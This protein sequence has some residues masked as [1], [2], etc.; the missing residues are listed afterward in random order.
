L[1]QLFEQ[2]VAEWL[3]KH[4]PPEYELRPQ[5]H[6]QLSDEERLQF[7]IDLV[8]CDR[9][10]GRPLCVRDT[11]YKK[12]EDGTASG[13]IAQVMA[14]AATQGGKRAVL[15]Y[16]DGQPKPLAKLGHDVRRGVFNLSG[17]L[18]SAGE[19]FLS[20]LLQFVRQE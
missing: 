19:A 16:P 11:K 6:V 14:Y 9:R 10:T 8:L 15:I 5:C 13:D 7:L 17:N 20:D 1:A 2:F 4:L 3:K 12:D 18:E